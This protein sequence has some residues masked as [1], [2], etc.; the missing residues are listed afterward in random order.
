MPLVN[1]KRNAPG[2]TEAFDG[3]PFGAWHR[4]Q[5]PDTAEDAA[6]ALV[7]RETFKTKGCIT[8]HTVRGHDGG[9]VTAPDL[10]HF[11]SRTTVAAGLLENSKP[12]V[13]RWI[14]APDNVKPGNKM[15]VGVPSVG[16]VVMPGYMRADESGA[17]TIEHIKV[18]DTEA[19]AIVEYLHSLK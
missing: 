8:C 7:G 16:G 2:Y 6:L 4:M 14:T 13:H 11:G 5:K 12:N 18:N 19:R 3:D 1:S 9:G 15:Y 17:M 10:T